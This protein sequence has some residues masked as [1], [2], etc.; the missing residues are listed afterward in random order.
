MRPSSDQIMKAGRPG[1]LL[2]QFS[3][4]SSRLSVLLCFRAF[5]IRFL[6]LP[7]GLA[8]LP[9]SVALA[10]DG[11]PLARDGR[12]LCAIVV[13]A[14]PS[15]A[16]RFASLE[17]A[18]HLG[19]MT[20]ARFTIRHAE[21]GQYP[22]I[23][24]ARADSNPFPAVAPALP[25]AEA[26]GYC[27]AVRGNQIY[28]LGENDRAVL[29]AVYAFLE[30]LGC[31]WLAPALGFY[32]GAHEIVPRRSD[33]TFNLDRD[34]VTRPALAFRKL[35]VEEGLSHTVENLRQMI[36]W[37]PR[38]GFN[39][40]VVPLD[41][42]GSGRVKWDNWRDVLTPELRRR[43]IIIEVGGHGYQNF[44]NARMEDG[45][46][47]REHPEWFGMDETG[48]RSRARNRVVCSSNSDAVARLERGVLD[49]LA[50]RPEIEIFDFWAPDGARWC[51]CEKCQALGSPSQR[52][53][54]LVAKV[55][56]AVRRERPDVRLECIAYSSYLEPPA[57]VSFDKSVLV[58][59]C[60]IAQ[61]FERQIDDPRSGVNAKYVQA[62]RAWLKVFPGDI[63]IYSYYRKYAWNSLP[64]IL[65]HYMGHDLRFYRKLGVHGVSTYAEPGDWATYELNHYVLGRLA[66]DPD[67]DVDALVKDFYVARYGQAAAPA[68]AALRT[69]ADVV[70]RACSL[71]GTS[72]KTP[73]E[74]DAFAARID[75]QLQ[76]VEKA[77]GE[78]AARPARPHL[79]RLALML[80][81][82]RRDLAL[83]RLRAAQGSPEEGRARV[84]ELHEFLQAN[85]D[86]GVFLAHRIK[87]N[88]LLNRYG[89][90]RKP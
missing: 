64:V 81:Y 65:P 77:A 61:C 70:P 25:K 52:H 71:P 36:D 53:A 43:G 51:E 88:R 29:Y 16:E 5:V 39:T 45:R 82:A 7:A 26:E 83:Q 24:V 20:G 59:F 73:A 74:Y 11:V 12:S 4:P 3:V 62:L 69:L 1:S 21:P 76:E 85:A 44:L 84:A 60:P 38:A 72:L 14:R 30:R 18:A 10:A 56:A 90:G 33:L 35:Y 75:D 78:D 23:V 48:R 41:Y 87:Q 13:P 63:S 19:E 89:L 49:Y 8:L 34:V 86:A 22:C 66:W 15:E 47:F 31:R 9:A 27:L 46:L 6:L 54:L 2:R 40:L 58:D 80:E 50:G 42:Q 67:A 55:A 37:M 68:E 57:E 17:L 79:R 28:L 32:E